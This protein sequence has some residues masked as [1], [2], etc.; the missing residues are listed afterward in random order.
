MDPAGDSEEAPHQ[1]KTPPFA[2]CKVQAAVGVFRFERD[3]AMLRRADLISATA[4]ATRSRSRAA[5]ASASASA[6][7]AGRGSSPA[8]LGPATMRRGLSGGTTCGG[9]LHR[10]HPGP[11]SR[12]PRGALSSSLSAAAAASDFDVS[13]LK[14]GAR[15]WCGQRKMS[16]TSRVTFTAPPEDLE[17]G[18]F[19]RPTPLLLVAGEGQPS[20]W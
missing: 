15:G 2:S 10:L 7:A 6:G 20:T 5:S 1:D 19:E 14:S 9:R 8:S 17:A 13:S 11:T 12:A 18:C 3:P 16:S 4:F